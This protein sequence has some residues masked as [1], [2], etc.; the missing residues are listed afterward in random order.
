[1]PC[2]ALAKQGGRYPYDTL[3]APWRERAGEDALPATKTRM[4]TMKYR[5][6]AVS[7]TFL[8]DSQENHGLET[9]ERTPESIA[10][11]PSPSPM[12]RNRIF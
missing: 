2:E 11:V 7:L 8:L 12:R 3:M 6:P 10:P 1:M 5:R 4:K 9:V